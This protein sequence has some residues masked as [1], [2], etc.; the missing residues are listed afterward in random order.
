MVSFAGLIILIAGVV[1]FI[2]LKSNNKVATSENIPEFS[3]N[4]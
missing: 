2:K 4:N 1:F 3:S